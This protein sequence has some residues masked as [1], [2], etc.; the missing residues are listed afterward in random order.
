MDFFTPGHLV[1]VAV[2]AVVVLV[3]WKRLP[4]MSRSIGRSLR[5]FKTEMKA[6]D[7]DIHDA[8]TPTTDPAPANQATAAHVAPHTADAHH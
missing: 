5:I 2:V 7:T 1:V 4:E 6:M 8:V 3:G